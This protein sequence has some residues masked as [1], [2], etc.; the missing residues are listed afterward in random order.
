LDLLRLARF[1]TSYHRYG[2][3]DCGFGVIPDHHP[4]QPNGWLPVIVA[5]ILSDLDGTGKGTKK[6]AGRAT[7]LTRK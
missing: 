3:S 7:G 5:K 1:S 2:E 4:G 6:E